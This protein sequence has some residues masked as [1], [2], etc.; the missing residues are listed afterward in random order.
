MLGSGAVAREFFLPAFEYLDRLHNLMVLD[1]GVPD[2]LRRSYPQVEFIEGDFRRVLAVL[3]DRHV[4]ASI[5]TLPN[6]L[7]EEAVLRLLETGAHVLCEKPL[8]LSEAACLR[9]RQAAVAA[10]RLLAVNM[11]RRLFPSIQSIHQMVREGRIGRLE[12]LSVQHGGAF[13]WPAQSLAPFLRVNG[14]VF[15]DMGVHYLDLAESLLGPLELRSYQDDSRGG[16]E[17]E[18]VA[19]LSSA[20]GAAVV[21]HLSRLRD[22]ANTITL[23]GSRGRIVWNVDSV[24]TFN[25]HYSASDDDGLEIRP[26]R[27]FALPAVPVSLLGCFVSQIHRFENRIAGGDVSVDEAEAAARSARLIEQAYER[28]ITKPRPLASLPVTREPGPALVTGA[29]G[30]I[31]SHLVER[32]VACGAEVTGLVRRPQT[33]A[34]VAR[35]PV[36]LI[37]ANLLDPDTIRKNME[38]KRYVFHLAYGRDGPDARAVTVQGTRNVVNAAI[39]AGCEAVVILSTINVLGWPEG[40]V[41]ESAA[42]HPVGGA[43][44]RTKASMERWCLARARSSG[45]TRIVVLLPSCVYGPGGKTFTELPAKLA[46]ENGFAWISGGQ[47]IANYVFIDNLVDAMV[48]AASSFQAHGERFIINDGWIT[49]REFLQPIISPWETKIRSFQPGELA[50]NHAKSRR[51]A[52]K[53]AVLAAAS[54]VDF[55]RELKKTM[56]GSIASR[57]MAGTKLVP[58]PAR[59][60]H[61]SPGAAD[62]SPEW[63]EDLFGTYK[64][65]FSSAKARSMLGWTPRVSLQE[66]QRLSVEYL[67]DIGLHP[68]IRD[69]DLV[70]APAEHS[71]ECSLLDDDQTRVQ[72]CRS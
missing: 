28:R 43:Y 27:P 45:N 25:L 52:L 68:H 72:L 42:Y 33:C 23:I 9:M 5:V 50:R 32:L 37:P 53:R 65:R 31:G 36:N 48:Q 49:W 59:V 51:G 41:V 21:V 22:L 29:T 15:A 47:G 57:V 62:A 30:F 34:S 26:L 2:E 67:R 54:N 8:A 69:P 38:G 19:E 13:H 63:I 24:S 46:S 64:T 71:S 14:G 58:H 18:A 55:R 16:V 7:H 17:A 10:R 70:A 66:G 44:G 56:L 11:V 20:S 39:E 60:P 61:I 4:T 35:F 6:D 3:R 40:E 1:L 12:R